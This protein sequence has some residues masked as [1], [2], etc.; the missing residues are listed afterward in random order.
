MERHLTVSG[1]VVHEG[2]VALHWH[3][4]V[5]M[6]LPAGGH[7][8]ANED[9][10][11]AVLRE[12]SEEFHVEAEVLPLASRTAYEGGPTQLEPPYTILT[13]PFPEPLH[14]H[15][16]MVYFCRLVSGYPGI[17]YDA[18]GPIHWFSE[19]ELEAGSAP[20]D[21]AAVPFPP[22]VQALGLEAIRLAAIDSPTLARP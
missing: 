4:K 19:P 12:I 16:D 20:R 11:Q 15:I 17:S 8:E 1:F 3:R 22:D 5:S 13:F 6:W 2:R 10:V 7:I 14:E 18:D 21:G 9:P